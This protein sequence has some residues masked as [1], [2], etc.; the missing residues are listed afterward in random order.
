MYVRLRRPDY[1]RASSYVLPQPR[2]ITHYGSSLR[3]SK[4]L[5]DGDIN[6]GGPL[7]AENIRGHGGGLLPGIELQTSWS[8]KIPFVGLGADREYIEA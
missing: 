1:V 6:G 2:L 3:T 5:D 4:L 8:G 7:E